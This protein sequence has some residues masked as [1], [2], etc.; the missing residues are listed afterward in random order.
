V[1][2]SFNRRDS[3]RRLAALLCVG[4]AGALP[5][6]AQDDPDP[7]GADLYEKARTA[8]EKTVSMYSSMAPAQYKVLSAAW[9]KRYPALEIQLVRADLGQTMERVLAEERGGKQAADVI[10]TNEASFAV[11]QKSKILTPFDSPTRKDWIEPFRSNFNGIQ[12]P[13]RVGHVCF[14]INTSK[15]KPEEAPK[16]WKDLLDKRWKGRLGVPD[17]RVG[18]G[19]QLWFMSLWDRPEYGARYFEALQANE[20]LVKPGII[21]VQQ[22]V[23]LGEVDIDVVAYDH[24]ALPARDA[25][26]PITVTIPSDGLIFIVTFESVSRSAPN[27]NAARLLTHFMMTPECQAAFADTYVAPVNSRARANPKAVSVEGVPVL[28]S[29]VTPEQLAKQRTYIAA[30]NSSFKL[31]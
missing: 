1:P 28:A 30:M 16:T 2:L 14:A 23:E 7:F 5:A 6:F 27:P 10:S 29:G 22:S 31:R 25:G 24:V 20:P 8:G 19:A 11:L 12:F 17:P 9:K 13:A 21:Q 4:Q 26:K 18:G 3:L 15:V